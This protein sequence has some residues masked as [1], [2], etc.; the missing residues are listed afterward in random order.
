MG[1]LQTA[2]AHDLAKIPNLSGER[3]PISFCRGN[4][5]A[6]LVVGPVNHGTQRNAFEKAIRNVDRVKFPH[7]MRDATLTVVSLGVLFESRARRCT[8]TEY[9]GELLM[10]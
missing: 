6:L 7:K 9:Q 3:T 8:G 10:C 2:H 4:A 5:F 1:Q